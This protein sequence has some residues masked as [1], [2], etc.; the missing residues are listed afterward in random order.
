MFFKKFGDLIV[1]V[2][3]IALSIAMIVA[4]QALPKSK[5]MDIGPD[6]M[7]TVIGVVSLV[8]ALGLLFGTLKNF[9][10]NA[11]KLATQK[12]PEYDYK[13]VILSML[14]V[15]AYV[16][17][18]KPIGFIVSTLVYLPLQ[19]IVL[20]PDDKRTKKDIILYVVINVIFTLAVFF[21]FR[22][23]FK[24]MMPAGIFTINL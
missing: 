17:T 24:I 3:F 9:K 12:A 1:S 11:A 5:V 7:P 2:F 13:R 15:L 21:L 16:F 22:Y 14:L 10:A 20:A 8:L 18:L 4:A 19:M 23:A 6:F